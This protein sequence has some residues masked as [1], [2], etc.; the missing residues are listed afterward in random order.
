MDN[1]DRQDEYLV[2]IREMYLQLQG[3]STD[4]FKTIL[5]IG[6]IIGLEKSLFML[7]K[8]CLEKRQDW[9]KKHIR[10]LGKLEEPIK[11]G[12][13]WFY[14]EYLHVSV[15]KDGEIVLASTDRMVTRWWNPCPTLDACQKL[16]L[17]TRQICKKVYHRPVEIILKAVH[18]GLRFNRNYACIRP[19]ADY[20]EEMIYLE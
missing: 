20:C 3:D 13:H 19:H 2:I 5:G 18:P 16:A 1:S 9:A 15:P 6:E 10:Q 11:A 17:D 8:C 12:Y 4:L 14:E 7:E